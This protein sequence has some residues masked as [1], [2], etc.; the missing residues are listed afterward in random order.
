MNNYRMGYNE[1][2]TW[3]FQSKYGTKVYEKRN[4]KK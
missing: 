3:Y 2:R 4:I 1:R